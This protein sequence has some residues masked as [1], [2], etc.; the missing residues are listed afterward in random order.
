MRPSYRHLV[1]SPSAGFRFESSPGSQVGR[2]RNR[3]TRWLT[4][5]QVLERSWASSVVRQ[6]WRVDQ[7]VKVLWGP[8]WQEPLAEPQGRRREAG[9]EGSGRQSPGPRNTNRIGGVRPVG[10]GAM[11]PEAQCHPDRA[12]VDAAGIWGESHA[13]Y[14]GRAVG[15]PC[16]SRAAR[17]GEASPAVS[18]GHSS[19]LRTGVKGQTQEAE[20]ARDVRC[21]TETQARRLR[22]RSRPGR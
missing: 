11:R 22:C 12:G 10:E 14:P 13:P 3:P 2:P 7:E 20:P 6:A 16:A 17:C 4:E 15:V 1:T 18:S 8:W 19:P 9:S 21:T 5:A